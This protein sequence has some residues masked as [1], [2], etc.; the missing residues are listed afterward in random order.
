MA[1]KA[2]EEKDPH[3]ARRARVAG[4][5]A[6][7]LGAIAEI[8]AF[9]FAWVHSQLDETYARHASRIASSPTHKPNGPDDHH[10]RARSRASIWG[11]ARRHHGR[12]A[13]EARGIWREERG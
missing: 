13:R 2:K 10:R 3:R 4:T 6:A 7:A 9:A 5:A 12:G 11:Q 1:K 8:L